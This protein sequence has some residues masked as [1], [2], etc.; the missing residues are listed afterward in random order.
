MQKQNFTLIEL[1]IVIAIIAILAAMLLP[2]LNKARDRARAANCISNYKQIG[3]AVH[4]YAGDNADLLLP[5]YIYVSTPGA[6]YGNS[7]RWYVMLVRRGYLPG[8]PDFAY[9]DTYGA[10][11]SRRTKVLLC[12]GYVQPAAD[13]PPVYALNLQYNSNS[14]K[15]ITRISNPSRTLYGGEGGNVNRGE[16]VW[17]VLEGSAAGGQRCLGFHHGPNANVLFVD[18]HVAGFTYHELSNNLIWPD[19]DTGKLRWGVN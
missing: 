18:G 14:P 3:L 1:L 8:V 13:A 4:S 11:Q 9:Y 19:Y 6:N 2:A 16:P 10:N 15:K 5:H 7:D 12:P 17:A